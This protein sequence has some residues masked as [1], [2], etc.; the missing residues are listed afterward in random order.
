MLRVVATVE[1]YVDGAHVMPL[2]ASIG[3][4]PSVTVAHAPP[5]VAP[6]PQ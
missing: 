4:A 6:L 2:A 3:A 1:E 5:E